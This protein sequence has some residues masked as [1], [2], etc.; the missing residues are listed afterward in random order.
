MPS[1]FHRE[2]AAIVDEDES[3]GLIP[4]EHDYRD[5]AIRHKRLELMGR[6]L[7]AR[8]SSIETLATQAT[9]VAGFCFAVLKPD[10]I[11]AV[12]EIDTVLWVPILGPFIIA[13]S[14]AI[15]LASAVWVVYLA[16]YASI[17]ARMAFLVGSSRRAIDES[18]RTLQLT[19]VEARKHFDISL[20]FLIISAAAVC[21]FELSIF[22]GLFVC[23][24]FFGYAIRAYHFKVLTID[25]RLTEWYEAS[26]QK[27][28]IFDDSKED[29][30]YVASIK[31]L[32]SQILLWL[33][34]E[35]AEPPGVLDQL[36][37]EPPIRQN[38]PEMWQLPTSSKAEARRKALALR[39]YLH[40]SPSSCGPLKKKQPGVFHRRYFILK[41]NELSFFQSKY[42]VEVFKVSRVINLQHYEVT[43]L[44]PDEPLTF[45]IVQKSAS[46]VRRGAH[47]PSFAQLSWY[48]RAESPSEFEHW[49]R[50]CSLAS[51][52]DGEPAPFPSCSS[53]GSETEYIDESFADSKFSVASF[54]AQYS[55]RESSPTKLRSVKR[56]ATERLR[57]QI[58]DV[59]SGR[60]ALRTNDTV[61]EM[62]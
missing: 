3:G 7:D 6:R 46:E 44:H 60:T 15:S 47:D 57:L 13:T 34:P 37:I 4:D 55:P 59:S 38:E 28:G 16:G 29:A 36:K 45:S 24:V 56:W 12:E 49:V 1:K 25:G 21:L 41:G 10:S 22:T 42:E 32:Y 40:K 61:M 35:Q 54:Q 48:L 23:F 5:K 17:K 51:L 43:S 26:E 53:P 31:F 58:G 20:T 52:L 2:V 39:G 11:F 27:L 14:N 30:S 18:V 19:H 8:I 9:L 62:V 50:N 33:R